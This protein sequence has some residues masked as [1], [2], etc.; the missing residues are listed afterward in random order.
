MYHCDNLITRLW[1]MLT[2]EM[3]CLTLIHK[4]SSRNGDAMRGGI[5]KDKICDSRRCCYII[6]CLALRQ[7]NLISSW[8]REKLVVVL[9]WSDHLRWQKVIS[10][11]EIVENST[12]QARF[13]VETYNGYNYSKCMSSCFIPVLSRCLGDHEWLLSCICFGISNN[14]PVHFQNNMDLLRCCTCLKECWSMDIQCMQECATI[15]TSYDWGIS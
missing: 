10:T 11:N 3:Q 12:F 13:Y 1:S 4:K 15:K 6:Q 2:L 7:G 5:G 8:N 14:I 9:G